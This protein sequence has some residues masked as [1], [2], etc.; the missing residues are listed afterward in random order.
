MALQATSR[1]I[2]TEDLSYTSMFDTDGRVQ[3]AKT[4]STL[5]VDIVSL[6]RGIQMQ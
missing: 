1:V 6:L 5:K 3:E 4:K 2:D